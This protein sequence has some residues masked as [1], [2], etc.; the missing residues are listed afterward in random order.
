MILVVFVFLR[1]VRA[2]LI[3]SVAVPASLIGTFGIMYLCGYSIDNLSLMALTIATGFVVDDAIVVIENITR[4]LE[5]GMKPHEAALR[6]AAEIGFTVMSISISLVAVFIPILLMGGIVGRLFRE[7]AVTLSVAIAVS[8]VI[9]LTTTPMM[10]ARLLREHAGERHGRLYNL[11]ERGFERI[12]SGYRA[13]L[14]W[15]LR[16]QPLTLMVTILT[17]A[18]TVYLYIAVPKGF[19]PQQ[20]TGRLTGQLVADQDTS[21]QAMK[22][23]LA[24][25]VGIVQKDP[26]VDSVSAFIGGQAVNQGRMFVNLKAVGERGKRNLNADQI[27]A[28]MRPHLARVPGLNLYLQPVQDLRVGGRASAAQY[29]YT[30][31]GDNTDELLRW[32]PKVLQTLR[33]LPILADV[34]TDQQDR[35]LESSLV[36]DRSTAS[37]MGIS[38]QTIDDTLYDAFGQRQVST[39]FQPLNQYHVVMEVAPQFWQN[40]D[41]LRY[42]YVKGRNANSPNGTLVPLSAFT[43][44]A[45]STTSLAVNHSGVF[46]SV[47]IS[48]NL[49][50]NQALGPAVTAIEQAERKIGLPSDIRGSF[51]GTAQAFQAS[52]ANEPLL[53]A[54]ALVTVYIVL[55]VLY[56]SVIHPITILSTLPSAGVGALLALLVTRTELIG[57]R[58][59]RHHPAHRNRQKERHP[60]DRFCDRGR[61]RAANPPSRRSS[62]PAC[63]ASGRSP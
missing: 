27:I 16:H 49:P 59:N 18:A 10:C 40:P 47:T 33:A 51:Q 54:A 29:Q 9:S 45:S 20:D 35:G 57:H 3:P 31:Q 43:H 55:G 22:T 41:G 5:A 50:A 6:G 11:S 61:T 15:V 32:A 38:A 44:Y 14:A 34:N 12:L 46:P 63:C 19:F 30:L 21:F 48:F 7:F 25:M 52:L 1:N 53:I 26:A 4:H 17:M 13:S 8:L 23:R 36:I 37:R 58:P 28:R 62:R 39:M 24:T 56:E 60:D 2:T 42:L